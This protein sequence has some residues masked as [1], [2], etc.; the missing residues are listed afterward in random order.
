MAYNEAQKKQ[1]ILELQTYL[2]AI[3]FINSEIPQ[4]TPNGIYNKE[5]IVAVR[6]FQRF[7]DLPETGNTD[8]VTWNKIVSVYRSHIRIA[9]M[10]YNVFPSENYVAH[11]GDNGHIVY[12]FQ[13]ML[14]YIAGNYDNAPPCTVCGNYNRE[15]S[16]MV[17]FFQKKVGLPQSG[18]IDSST[19]NML[20]TCC[21]HISSTSLKSRK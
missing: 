11:L 6:A 18:N 21:E 14:S 20:I 15:T 1:H 2:Y 7:Y 5:T 16:E 9:P 17:R 13:A 8:P 4:V 3:S 19:W 12:I 10:P